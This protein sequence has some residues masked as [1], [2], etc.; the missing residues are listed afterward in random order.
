MQ[1]TWPFVL[2]ALVVA[3]PAH[4]IDAGGVVLALDGGQ[5]GCP[6]ITITPAILPPAIINQTYGVTFTGNG[7]TGPYSYAVTTGTLPPGLTLL[8][9]GSFFGAPSTIGTYPITVQIMDAASCTG[10]QSFTLNV[11]DLVD[12]VV[13]E[14]LGI[15]NTNRVRVHRGDGSFAAVDFQAY[16]AGKWGTNVAAGDID[17]GGQ[18]E[19]ITGPGPGDVYGPQVRGWKRDGTSMGKINYYAYGTLRYGA[20]VATG[21]LDG[22]VFEEIQT[23]AGPGSVFGPHMRGWNFDGTTVTAIAKINFFAYGTLRYGVNPGVGALDA[24]AYDELLTGAGPGAVFAPQVR[25]WNVDGGTVTS[26]SKINYFA[27][28]AIQ[29]GVNIAAGDVEADTFDEIVTAKGP[30]STTA[31]DALVL[32]FDYDDVAV[33]A[34]PGFAVIAHPSLYGARVG[35]GDVVAAGGEELLTG[36]GRDPA[37]VS[38]VRSYAYDGT[39]LTLLSNAFTPFTGGY[40]VNVAPGRLGY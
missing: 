38:T 27:Y 5:G 1:R 19:M 18:A 4:A 21:L 37:A 13:G 15:S 39:A 9:A 2:L 26:M 29:Y 25:G 34:A 31:Y 33:V 14:G 20:N 17:G 32:G 30:G 7:G 24:D 12:Y 6:V 28:S 10:S 35:V 8:V 40:G 16:G 3:M 23:G 22:D 11:L 36:A